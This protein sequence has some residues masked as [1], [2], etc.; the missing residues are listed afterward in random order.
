MGPHSGE[1]WNHYLMP[2]YIDVDCLMPTGVLIV[3]KCKR[4]SSLEQVKH[5][6]WKE[7]QGYPL[8]HLL[9]SS[10]C[11]IFKS[12]TLD[13]KIEE[14]YDETRRLC[15]LRLFHP[16]LKVVLP[17]GNREEMIINSDIGHAMGMSITEFDNIKTLEVLT[18]R[19]KMLEVCQESIAKRS[20]PTR[21]AL[22]KF[23]PCI[24]SKAEPP[25][26]VKLAVREC[27]DVMVICVW[28]VPLGEANTGKNRQR[29]I[30]KVNPSCT[31][32]ELVYEVIRKRLVPQGLPEDQLKANCELFQRDFLLRVC[33]LEEYLL[34]PCP[35]TQYKY[36]R[37]CLL[38]D[39]TPQLMLLHKDTF[40]PLLQELPFILPSFH[41]RGVSALEDV[42]KQRKESLWEFHTPLRVKVQIAQ[43]VTVTEPGQLFVRVGVYHGLDPICAV[44][45]TKYN[46]AGR[47]KWDE[48]LDFE[49]SMQDIPRAAKLCMGLCFL[50]RRRAK[51]QQSGV[52]V[53]CWGNINLFNFL[54][55]LE[56]EKRKIFMVQATGFELL[57]PLVKQAPS[58]NEPG[59]PALDIEFEGYKY[60]VTYP[61]DPVVDI[62]VQAVADR[63][64]EPLEPG[65]FVK[66]QIR[67]IAAKD[68]LAELADQDKV[69]LW[70]NRYYCVRFPHV[71]PKL[72][73]ATDWGE[74]RSVMEIYF[75]LKI[76][77]IIEPEVA[78]ALLDCSYPDPRVR[79]YAVHCLEENL[80]DN[81]LS[82]YLLQLVQV[83]KFELYIDNPLTRF[84][85][86]RSLSNSNIGH[87]FF[88]HIKSEMHTAE[89][90]RFGLILEAYCRGCGSYLKS[91]IRQV[92]ALDK[93][94]KLTDQL[95]TERD[96]DQRK[97]LETQFQ[98]PDYIDALQHLSSPLDSSNILGI[99]KTSQCKVMQSKKRP[100]KLT[101]SN[102]CPLAEHY[103]SEFKIIFKNGDDLRQDMLTLQVIRIMDN[104]WQNEGMDLKMLPYNV[105]ATGNM[106]GLINVVQ[107][108]ETVMHIQK[109]NLT[110]AMQLSSGQ[111]HKWLKENNPP[112]MY[113]RVID[114]F[115]KSSV[116]YT[117]ATYVLGIGDRHP[118]NIMVTTDGKLF[119]VDFG[120]FLNHKKK[121]LGVNRER[122]P[123]VLTP[124]LINT[125]ARGVQNGITSREFVRFQEMCGQAFLCLRKHSSLLC[126]LFSM[127]L[128]S[129]IQELQGPN[130]I[131][132]LR[133]T[134][135]V[136]LNDEQAIEI[137]LQKFDEAYNG[138]WTQRV[139]WFFHWLKNKKS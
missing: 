122:V 91:L 118:D 109:S 96:D 66:D 89:R 87:F 75:L 41:C 125:I 6:L 51:K 47:P 111:L 72:L 50:P 52:T 31:P 120:H 79:A 9:L 57:N 11:Y 19:R 63:Y 94:T 3:Q 90:K 95:K 18:F 103:Q 107:K 129:G 123:F 30:V 46:D 102:D 88:W 17:E 93:L 116:G 139:D 100:L 56:G 58:T 20:D 137:F 85:L 49:L 22:Y 127:M 48:V 108:A 60:F 124:D 105:L 99:L 83:I 82:L 84:L 24:E 86:R 27:G 106:V 117:V 130:D 12:V 35:L 68:G 62:E 29:Y 14:F 25:D 65:E 74:R 97:V 53:L 59:N 92:D 16:M 131:E 33:G 71:L 15:D 2:T 36:I 55:Q 5:D 114:N 42:L 1:L 138:A 69:A 28:V 104:I 126:T 45:E 34:E 98:K 115:T 40:L 76:W 80:D 23:P 134:L 54:D 121:K 119:H 43:Y 4:E 38:E 70:A 128:N 136:D 81:R 110:N 132:Y 26:H 8:F 10:N 32:E 77:P 37:S 39:K 73:T 61:S 112:E 78:L 44:K 113:N 7:A 67:E 21:L 135:G 101:W 133:K 13:A 64:V